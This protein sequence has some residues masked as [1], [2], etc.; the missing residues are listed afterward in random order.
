MDSTA[1]L[2]V[3]SKGAYAVISDVLLIWGWIIAL[4]AHFIQDMLD[5]AFSPQRTF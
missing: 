3:P 5:D 1:L 4:A 2:V